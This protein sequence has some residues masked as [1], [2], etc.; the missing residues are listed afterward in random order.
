MKT[1]TREGKGEKWDRKGKAM[2]LTFCVATKKKFQ[3]KVEVIMSLVVSC[4]RQK[5]VQNIEWLSNSRKQNWD[6]HLRDSTWISPVCHWAVVVQKTCTGCFIVCLLLP[7]D[8]SRHVVSDYQAIR[9]LMNLGNSHR[10]VTY[11]EFQCLVS[12]HVLFTHFCLVCLFHA[13]NS[14]CLHCYMALIS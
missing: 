11:L 9:D 12:V 6:C 3:H 2:P 5:T 8:L 14:L 13:T 4:K 1:T 10:L 7:A